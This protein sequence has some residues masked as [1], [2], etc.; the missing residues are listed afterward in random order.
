MNDK[1]KKK[2]QVF[3][4][5]QTIIIEEPEKLEGP[6]FEK[7]KFW[8]LKGTKAGLYRFYSVTALTGVAVLFASFLI[9]RSF[10][11]CNSSYPGFLERLVI[12][13]VQKSKEKELSK[14]IEELSTILPIKYYVSD[15]EE[16]ETIKERKDKAKIVGLYS[17]RV[18]KAN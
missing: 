12:K 4:N 16:R 11:R 8:M 9:M 7:P 14:P 2:R 3:S 5:I 17:D 6:R 13:E 18:V 10:N 15:Q 1:V